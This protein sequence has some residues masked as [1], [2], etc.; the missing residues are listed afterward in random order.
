MYARSPLGVS[1]AGGNSLTTRNSPY[2]RP[3]LRTLPLT[4]LRS[5][6]SM[7]IDTP[8][9]DASRRSQIIS[10]DN[11]VVMYKHRA[12][13]LT[14][15]LRHMYSSTPDFPTPDGA[16]I[17]VRDFGGVPFGFRNSSKNSPVEIPLYSYFLR[18]SR[19]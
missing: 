8:V 11:S 13:L 5:F 3:R 4:F 15:A 6:S 7:L 12:R 14:T 9:N 2:F 17:V 16:T 10:S 1:V 18:R 19:R